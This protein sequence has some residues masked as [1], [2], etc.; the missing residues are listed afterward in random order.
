MRV[1][2]ASLENGKLTCD[3]KESEMQEPITRWYCML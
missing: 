2:H 1:R 3:E